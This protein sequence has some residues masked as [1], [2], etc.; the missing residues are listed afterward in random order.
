MTETVTR[1]EAKKETEA[2]R[3][4]IHERLRARLAMESLSLESHLDEDTICAFV[5]G[6]LEEAESSPVISH[7]IACTSC[8]QTTAQLIRF[9]SQFDAETESAALEE[10]PGRV[11]QLLDR[12]GSHVAPPFEEDTV[13][14]YHDPSAESDQRTDVIT[15]SKPESVDDDD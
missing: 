2:I 4:M 15:E 9:G 11:R 1:S 3:Y 8:R 13:F 7:L 10:N 12:L 6:R 14:A 5:E